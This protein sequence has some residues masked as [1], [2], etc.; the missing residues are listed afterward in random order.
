[1]KNSKKSK[2]GVGSIVVLFLTAMLLSPVI[3]TTAM[4]VS[5]W[6]NKLDSIIINP[7]DEDDNDGNNQ[8]LPE[9]LDTVW[10]PIED[11]S[12]AGEQNDAGS[13]IDAGDTIQRSLQLF[14]G[15]PVDEMIPGRG[16]TG[17]LDPDEGDDAD[18][19][20]YL[21]CE[22]Q[23]I[24]VSID[25]FD[26]Q[27]YAQSLG[28]DPQGTSHTATHTE[29]HFI[30]ITGETYGEYTFSIT[31]SG[32]NDAGTGGD[33]GDSIDSATS[34]TPGEYIGYM[35]SND[36]EDWYSF[37]ANANDGIFINIDTMSR[38][39][40]DYDIHLYNPS[41]ELAHEAVFYGSDELE[42]PADASGTWSIKI[43]MF[44]GWDTS[45]WPDNYFLYGC[46]PYTLTLSIGGT[47]EAP[48]VPQPQPDITP[49]AQTFIV[50]DDLE[51]TKDE[52]GYLAAVPAANYIEGGTRYVCPIIY[53]GADEVTHWYGTI[54]DTTQYLI[55]DWNTY[56]SRHG[57]E[58]IEINVA[59]DP[60]QA[61]ANIATTKWTSSDTAVIAV[62]GSEF[63][64]EVTQVVK[65]DTSI[66]SPPDIT[67]YLPDELK[68][69]GGLPS[70]P[71]IL[72]PKWGAIHVVALGEGF[73]GDTGIITH[74]YESLMGDWWPYPYPTAAYPGP[75]YDTF[76]P[77]SQ[78]GFWIPFV[79]STSGLDELQIIKY[80]GDRYK[81]PIT[82][83][84]SSIEVTV[85]TNE[86]SNLIVYLI[87]PEGNVRR[88]TIPHWNGGE[89]NP[90]HYWNGGHWENDE[91]EFRIWKLDPHTEFSVNVNHAMT[92]TW[93]AIVVPYL[94]NEEMDV[95]FSGN[96]HI[97]AN[98]RKYNPDRIN[99][100]LSAANA[101][102][103][104][105]ANHVPLLYVTKDSVPTETSNALTQLGVSNIIYIN[106]NGVSSASLSG[107]VNECTTMQEVVADIK[108][109]STSENYITITS[110][111]TGD[112]YFAPAAMAA[113]YH[114]S[115]VLNIGEAASAYNMLDMARTWTEYKGDYYHG[116]RSL[117][118]IPHMSEPIEL[119]NPPSWLRL[120]IYYIMN[121]ELPPIGLDLRLQWYGGIY[122]AIHGMA[123]K[124]N[125]DVEGKEAY[126][127]V[128]PRDTDI[129]DLTSRIMTGNNSY[130]GQ[131]MFEKTALSSAHINRDILYP[132]VV[133]ANEGR[134][135]IS[136][137]FMNYRDGH[138]WTCN[139]G[140]RYYDYVTQTLKEMGTSRGRFF[141]GHSLWENLLERYNDGCALIYHCSHGTGGSGICC[142]Y[143][144]IEEQF[145]LAHPQNE[146]R[147]DF[148]WWD[149]WRGYYYDNKKIQ[150]PRDVG[151]TWVNSVEPNLYDIIHFKYCDQ[152]F[153]NLHSQFNF[154]MSCT[155]GS[156]FGPNVYLEH[157]CALWFG[158]GN[159]GR[160]PQEEVLDQWITEDFMDKGIGIG[161][162]LSNYMWLHQR[163]FTTRDPTTIYGRSSVLDNEYL[164]NEQ[165]IFGDPNIQIYS[166]EWIE[167]TPI[168][169]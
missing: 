156:H 138:D 11:V 46:G 71:M 109:I 33:A 88:P 63:E 168:N 58:A 10:H 140:V 22:G 85:S 1:M 165:M 119:S 89:I 66:S 14:V 116:C 118:H 67:T 41:G 57:T 166:P 34:I 105:S 134:H 61:A 122:D 7:F 130:A 94:D 29:Y 35:D 114:V 49:I 103:I 79:S 108:D 52:Y 136:S 158:N 87:D 43:D 150:T 72:G 92:G 155:T 12:F 81:I 148:D 80:Q 111:G 2:I 32:Q 26:I 93:T 78:P 3:S 126:L 16:R 144:N 99:A 48:I 163:D 106:I 9:I 98:V 147:K 36:W 167:P 135:V 65:T 75:D 128:S 51:S 38:E 39:T 8:N 131:I 23:S 62:D 95:G 104:A 139:D 115:P 96:Y 69:F 59:D 143:E 31:I 121:N 18:W 83:T 6:K 101:A 157:G 74:R 17:T 4:N 76:F 132:A 141:E 91:D 154:W 60:I 120:I 145:P 133:Y 45:K 100:G 44:P 127:F 159:T 50:N 97:E 137:C 5:E 164:A 162:A 152:L 25:M 68:D 28:L 42:Y 19:Y 90:I 24:S 129:R 123:D 124:Y 64:D 86:P 53:Q 70:V 102:V 125:L 110:F 73:T 146:N 112:G 21:V 40:A 169:G 153:D 13:N 142:M 30:A 107:T 77:V 84:D 149:G 161:E 47:A 37:S 56:L 113:A 15:E 27:I 151:L 82:S 55:D 117:G 20:K 54:D 160:S